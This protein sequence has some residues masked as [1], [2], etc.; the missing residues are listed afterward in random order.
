MTLTTGGFFDAQRP[1]LMIEES[2]EQAAGQPARPH[3]MGR[4][5]RGIEG[6]RKGAAGGVVPATCRAS[7]QSG[8]LERA[9]ASGTVVPAGLTG[10]CPGPAQRVSSG[11]APGRIPGAL[12]G[13]APAA[14]LPSSCAQSLAAAGSE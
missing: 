7:R 2:I 4:I 10:D 12:I 9:R 3:E 14:R 13:M 6:F 11:R 5:C 8:A 1:V